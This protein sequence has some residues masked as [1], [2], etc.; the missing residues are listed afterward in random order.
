M[1]EKKFRKSCIQ[2]TYIFIYIYVNAYII[3]LTDEREEV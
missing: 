2:N 1:S 3:K